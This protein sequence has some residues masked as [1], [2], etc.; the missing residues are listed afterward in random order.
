MKIGLVRHFKVEIL[1]ERE[2]RR[3]AYSGQRMK[4][5]RN[6]QLYIYEKSFK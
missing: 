4:H 2:L 5:P 3:R 1:P 6:G